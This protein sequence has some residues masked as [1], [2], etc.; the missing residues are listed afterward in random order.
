M[1][2]L[3][4]AKHLNYHKHEPRDLEDRLSHTV[5]LITNSSQVINCLFFL[6]I[7]CTYMLFFRIIS[8]LLCIIQLLLQYRINHSLF[9]YLFSYVNTCNFQQVFWSDSKNLT[10]LHDCERQKNFGASWLFWLLH[11]I[12][13]LTYLLTYLLTETGDRKAQHVK[14]LQL[15]VITQMT[16]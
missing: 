4:H 14:I 2:R 10:T 1:N 7:Y 9:Y 5:L 6:L 11:L 12:N 13:T 3:R 8:S 16:I 15:C